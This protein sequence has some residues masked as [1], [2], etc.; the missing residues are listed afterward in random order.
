MPFFPM[1]HEDNAR[2]GFLSD[3]QCTK[4]RDALPDEL[5]P[6]LV[7]AYYMGVRLGELLAWEW[8]QVDWAQLFHHAKG[9]GD[10][11]RL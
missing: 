2:Q 5:K 1:V 7:T 3:Q 6:L 10:E 4:L 8:N 11:I 9:G